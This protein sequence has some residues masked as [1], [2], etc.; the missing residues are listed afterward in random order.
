PSPPHPRRRP[1][2]LMAHHPRTRHSRCHHHT[3]ALLVLFEHSD[4]GRV[5][6]LRWGRN[7]RALS[8]QNPSNTENVPSL[9]AAANNGHDLILSVGHTRGD[10]GA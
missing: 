4:I 3:Q 8:W 7:D 2:H 1:H 9:L 6:A 5:R 10:V